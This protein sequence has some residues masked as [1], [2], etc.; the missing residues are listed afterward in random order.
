MSERAITAAQKIAGQTVERERQLELFGKQLQDGL[1]E[2]AVTLGHEGSMAGIRFLKVELRAKTYM[3]RLGIEGRITCRVH[4]NRE[5]VTIS[6]WKDT[7]ATEIEAIS[8]DIVAQTD[9]LADLVAEMS[10][11]EPSD[12]DAGTR[13]RSRPSSLAT[14]LRAN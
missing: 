1:G 7:V 14:A 9:E 13:P 3:I 8:A 12:T 4:G 10:P 11:D 6:E 5:D 2:D